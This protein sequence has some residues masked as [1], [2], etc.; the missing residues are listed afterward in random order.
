MNLLAGDESTGGG[1]TTDFSVPTGTQE[2]ISSDA[3]AWE[4][5]SWAKDLTVEDEILKSNMFN[6]VKGVDDIVRG[7]YHAQKLV[8]HDK[9]VVPN[10]K[11]TPEQWRAYYGK[12][13]LPENTESYSIG[14]ESLYADDDFKKE[15]FEKAHA[16]YIKPDQ[17]KEILSVVDKYNL[18]VGEMADRE[19][20]ASKTAIVSELKT[21]WGSDFQRNIG[22]IN[23]T[24]KH[25][26]G[27]EMHQQI[28]GSSLAN[29]KEFI[30][31]MHMISKKLNQEDTFSRDVR[32]NFAMSKDDAQMRLNEIYGD[33]KS[34]YF[35]AQHPQKQDV[36]NEVLKLQ[37]ILSK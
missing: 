20:E 24:I 35:Q 11:S 3:P 15:L 2:G 28:M 36:L 34:P 4:R 22:V 7:Y 19:A 26:V 13:G 30:Q 1:T 31:T 25:L 12:A 33:A 5:Q 6:S 32:S 37:E 18:Q 21:E 23:E 29:S 9:I 16:N 10:E 8:G 27:D 17:L 14:E